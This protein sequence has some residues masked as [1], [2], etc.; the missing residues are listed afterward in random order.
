[1]S[2]DLTIYDAID[3][4][5]IQYNGYAFSRAL[6]D[7]MKEEGAQFISFFLDSGITE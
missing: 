6:G 5:E 2:N 4:N 1:M 3:V 7:I